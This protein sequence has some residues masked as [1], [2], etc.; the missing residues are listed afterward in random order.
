VRIVLSTGAE[1]RVASLEL[2]W[3]PVQIKACNLQVECAE[4][5]EGIKEKPVEV[6]RV[7]RTDV[8]TLLCDHRP[9]AEVLLHTL[10]ESALVFQVAHSEHE[11]T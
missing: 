11:V 8:I 4:G 10:L 3:E 9:V 7:T 2:A 6:P 5:H 1:L